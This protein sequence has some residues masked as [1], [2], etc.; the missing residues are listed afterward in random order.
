MVSR[1][2]VQILRVNTIHKIYPQHT[3]LRGNLEKYIAEY[4]YS[5][6]YLAFWAQLFKTND[7]V[8]R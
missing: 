1:K 3:F 6:D 8:T 4:M 5:S 2:G 7:V